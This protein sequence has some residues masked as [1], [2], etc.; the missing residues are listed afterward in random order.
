MEAV[1]FITGE[2]VL[3]MRL[4]IDR[5]NS[6]VM[7]YPATRELY[8]KYSLGSYSPY[9]RAGSM[10]SLDEVLAALPPHEHK[11]FKRLWEECWP[12]PPFG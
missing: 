2:Q 6:I 1:M 4:C 11:E 5:M 8:L 3:F 9:I 12:S 7:K 10:P